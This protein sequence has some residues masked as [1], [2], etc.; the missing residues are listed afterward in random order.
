MKEGSFGG[1]SARLR[2]LRRGRG[3]RR[4][5]FGVWLLGLGIAI[6]ALY[7]RRCDAADGTGLS[8][9]IVGI[10]YVDEKQTVI[11][12]GVGRAM[13]DVERKVLGEENVASHL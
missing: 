1:G 12:Q 11:E 10:C 3:C 6:F 5:R 4:C 2:D 7:R 9:Y 8:H 13:N